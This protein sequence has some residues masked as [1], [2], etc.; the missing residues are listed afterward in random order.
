MATLP[1]SFATGNWYT[2]K[3]IANRMGKS[4]RTV[5]YWVQRGLFARMG[6]QVINVPAKGYSGKG[7]TWIRIPN[8]GKYAM[9]N[10][11]HIDSLPKSNIGS[12][13]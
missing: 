13:L 12:T 8:T 10:K 3:Y 4:R 5:L 6:I 2:I 1:L 7:I 9:F 11:V